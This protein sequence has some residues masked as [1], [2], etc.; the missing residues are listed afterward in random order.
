MKKDSRLIWSQLITEGYKTGKG[1]GNGPE[2][3]PS[4]F[5]TNYAKNILVSLMKDLQRHMDWHNVLSVAFNMVDYQSLIHH[6]AEARSALHCLSSFLQDQGEMVVLGDQLSWRHPLVCGMPQ[7]GVISPKLFNIYMHLLVQIT[8]R[9]RLGYHQ[10]T[11]S[12]VG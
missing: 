12:I 7:R 3:E 2:Q 11:L 6:H 10:Y 4:G 5:H 9:Y 1:K 8:Q